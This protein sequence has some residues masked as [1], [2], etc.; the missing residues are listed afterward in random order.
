MA[1]DTL[2][3]SQANGPH[4]RLAAMAGDWHGT[5]R[6]WFEPDTIANESSIQGSLRLVLGGR[7]LLHEYECR[8]QGKPEHG[9]ALYGHHL[10]EAQHEAVW[11]DTFHTGTSILFSQGTGEDFDVLGTYF[12]GQGEP[13]WGWRTTLSQ[14]D[15]NRLLIVM[16][17]RFPSGE[18][19][20]AV[21]FDYRRA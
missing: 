18:E 21:E 17:N 12:A 7:F 16:Y 10:D 3:A 4:A 11:V 1:S 8:M 15:D 19:A 9:I 13:R 6:T 20:R 14:P 2:Q 5:T